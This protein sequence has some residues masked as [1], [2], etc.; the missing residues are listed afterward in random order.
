MEKVF[1]FFAERHLIATV[2]TLM[3]FLIGFSVSLTMKRDFLPVVNLSIVSIVTVYPGA[4]PQD[5]ELNITNPIEDAINEITGIEKTTSLSAEGMSTVTITLD[6]NF[7][8]DESDKV[9]SEIKDAVG[10]IDDFPLD[11]RNKPIVKN[12]RS[13]EIPILDVGLSSHTMTYREL[14]EFAKSFEKKLK[15]L[16]GVARFNR[17][18][19]RDR[20]VHIDILPDLMRQ[21]RIPLSSIV[22]SIKNRNI[23]ET[24]GSIE[25]YATGEDIVTLGQFKSP[26][27]VKKVVVQATFGGPAITLDKISQIKDTFEDE[28]II[29]RINAK[30]VIYYSIYKKESSDIVRTTNMIKEFIEKEKKK[31]N[32]KANVLLANDTSRYVDAGYSVVINNG[33]MGLLIVVILLSVF[34]RFRISMWVALGIPISILAAI[35]LIPQFGYSMN[36]ISLSALILVLGIIVDDAIIISESIYKRWEDGEEPVDAAVNGIKSVFWPV[37]TTVFTTCLAFLPMFLIPGTTGK[38]IFVI[39]LVITLSVIISLAEGVIALPAHI[40]ISLKKIK[41]RTKSEVSTKGYDWFKDFLIRALKFR[42]LLI[43]GFVILLVGS[44]ILAAFKMEV[45]FF[46]DT[47]ADSFSIFIET[48]VG[49]PLKTTSDRVKKIEDIL[50]KHDKKEITSFSTLIGKKREELR[51]QHYGYIRVN[52]SPNSE[53]K[54]SAQNIADALRKQTSRLKGFINIIYDIQAA[55]PR[56]KKP[57]S[58]RLEG[59][60]N[61]ERKR[62]ANDLIDLLKKQKGIVDITRDDTKGKKQVQLIL[63]YKL[64]ARA[65]LSVSDVSTTLRT[66]FKGEDVTRVQ[67]ADEEV[68]F[69]VKMAKKSGSGTKNILNKVFIPNKNGQFI[70]LN[71][72]AAFKTVDGPAAMRHYN[73]ERTIT[74]EASV[75]KTITSVK[76]VN[77]LIKNKFKNGEVYKGITYRIAGSAVNVSDSMKQFLITFVIAILGI[78]FL[79]LILFNSPLQ[80][81]L[82]MGAIPFGL[83][84]VILAFAIHNEPLSFMAFL[85]IVGLSGVVVNDSLVLVHQINALKKKYI[86]KT[87]IEIVAQG[88]ADRLRAVLITT[89]TTAS[90][91]LPLAYGIGG[92]DPINA[93]MA[94]AL[95][96]GL[97]F[98]TPLTLIL[99]PCFYCISNDFSEA[100]GHFKNKIALSLKTLLKRSSHVER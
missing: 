36:V 91:V 7:T 2:F 48:P 28:S 76:K 83:T 29:P 31:G 38:F 86:D 1:R 49:T 4:S 56:P 20:E 11:L 89:I 70:P 73:G 18:G 42:Y 17:Y 96:W 77:A 88:S 63:N 81:F 90:G 25:T 64:L 71:R 15:N 33:I 85:G 95:G 57:I 74:V 62:F 79:L 65:G 99:V 9:A 16:Q 44:I 100:A 84:G 93:P 39:P 69:V 80:P 37:V 52:L 26:L 61:K 54:N 75:E 45:I 35:S 10:R 60:D 5:V 43:G 82:V 23:S 27:D 22:R 21:Y 72:L 66:A 41:I 40:A 87:I 46:P 47:G 92:V 3:I 59:D 67:Y 32:M 53:R 30:S 12:L 24:S 68:Y 55:G 34:L 13:S 94:L 19:F 98:A 50:L 14:R 8:D 97:L 58:I 78:Y 6:Q 51:Q